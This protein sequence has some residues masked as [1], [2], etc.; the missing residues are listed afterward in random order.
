MAPEVRLPKLFLELESQS[1][2]RAKRAYVTDEI[3]R[4]IGDGS[5]SLVALLNQRRE[6]VQLAGD[7]IFGH[8]VSD[9]QDG[10]EMGQHVTSIRIPEEIRRATIKIEAI[11]PHTTLRWPVGQKE[12]E[13]I[14]VGSQSQYNVPQWEKEWAEE[15]S[16]ADLP[17]RDAWLCLKRSGQ[18]V[19]KAQLPQ[20][21]KDLWLCREV[22]GSVKG[23]RRSEPA[24]GKQSARDEA[25]V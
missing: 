12:V 5:L 21:K 6:A 10:F 8:G 9:G 16:P 15:N 23:N 14:V 19:V 2:P 3:V 4:M 1:T 17:L 11:P 18:Y 24:K 13:G 7:V 22:A 20:D 25:R